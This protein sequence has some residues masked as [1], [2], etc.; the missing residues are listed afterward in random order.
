MDQDEA[1]GLMC[2]GDFETLNRGEVS[3]AP[4]G[5]PIPQSCPEQI[6]DIIARYDEALQ[7][8]QGQ[9][10]NNVTMVKE[11]SDSNEQLRNDKAE[12]KHQM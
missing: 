4:P 12:L 8:A 10:Q 2:P 5:T 9:N 1:Q 11:L 6:N 7:K 3:S